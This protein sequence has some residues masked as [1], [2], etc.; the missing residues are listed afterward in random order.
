MVM[1]KERELTYTVI[2]IV[3]FRV[4]RMLPWQQYIYYSSKPC[5]VP[6]PE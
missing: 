4:M 5:G 2:H 1:A 6:L 3:R